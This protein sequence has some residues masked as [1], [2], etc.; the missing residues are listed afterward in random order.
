MELKSKIADAKERLDSIGQ[1]EKNKDNFISAVRKFME[2]EELTAPLLKELIERIEVN[3]IE[4]VGKNQIQR[5][6]IHY[7]FIGC[8]E[9]PM[10]PKC[11]NIKL[12]TRKGVAVE[13]LPTAI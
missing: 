12:N 5:F 9:V 6:S 11:K 8:I 3:H 2:M 10:L 1:I 4:G 7:K 13:Y